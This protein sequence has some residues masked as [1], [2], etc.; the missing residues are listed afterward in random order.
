M[1]IGPNDIAVS[2]A[3]GAGGGGSAFVAIGLQQPPAFRTQYP[4]LADFAKLARLDARRGADDGGRRAGLAANR[5]ANRRR[6][7]RLQTLSGPNR[8]QAPEDWTPDG[9][10]LVYRARQPSWELV[11]YTRDREQVQPITPSNLFAHSGRVAP[12]GRW[13]TYYARE[14]RP[15]QV[16]VRSMTPGA[17]RQQVS[18]DGGSGSVWAPDGRRIY[19]RGIRGT[20]E[21]GIWAV[22][23]SEHGPGLRVGAPRLLFRVDGY[24][25][26]FDITRDG[27]HFVMVREEA[28]Q[29]TRQVQVVLNPFAQTTT[30]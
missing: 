28:T 17:G 7:R 15:P 3:L 2:P 6:R 11:A 27:Q 16:Y 26:A 10:T 12:N 20:A 13:L 25:E 8:E 22:D 1:A 19:Y 23:V 30:P 24:A 4:F 9:R 5:D 21:D 29:E 18:R 14:S